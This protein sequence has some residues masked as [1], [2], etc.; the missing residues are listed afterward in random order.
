MSTTEQ[1]TR[2]ATVIRQSGIDSRDHDRLLVAFLPHYEAAITTIESTKDLI[3]HDAS[4]LSEMKQSR[5]ARLALKEVRVAADKLRK[6]EKEPFM[7]SAEGVDAIA[8]SIM[9][10]LCEPAEKRL[11]D[12]E[13]FA[14]R[15]E[16][17]RKERV[18]N[19][20]L[21]A[22]RPF[23]DDVSVYRAAVTDL[24]D[25][26]WDMLIDSVRRGYESR[27]EEAR[28]AEMARMEAECAAA[29]REMQEQAKREAEEA[30]IRA[31]NERLRAEQIEKDREAKIAADKARADLETANRKAREERAKAEAKLKAEREE[32]AS[33]QRLAEARAAEDRRIAKEKAD[34]QIREERAKREAAERKVR[35]EEARIAKEA[36]DKK[37]E[38]ERLAAAPDVEKLKV[39]ASLLEDVEW[40]VVS[41]PVAITALTNIQSK[42]DGCVVL[43]RSVARNM[44]E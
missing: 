5:E 43:L 22:L 6:K 3:V 2:L 30:R 13:E 12:Q 25:T 28:K 7:R 9:R 40:P 35:E 11:L 29:E 27:V 20:R 38:A 1:E 31:E 33:K 41:T 32:A 21:A 18:T 44:T 19:D 42:I 39:F 23:V 14:I 34:A 15:A 24:K 8:Y 10:E 17:Q 4:Q 37:R 36:A 16:A 26:A